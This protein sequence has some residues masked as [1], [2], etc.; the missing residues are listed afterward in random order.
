MLFERGNLWAKRAQTQ[1]QFIPT[2][3]E[4]VVSAQCLAS[5]WC[6]VLKNEL[7][8]AAVARE[9]SWGDKHTNH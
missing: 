3:I 1:I 7:D 9:S 8:L 2:V 5:A 6:R 4:C